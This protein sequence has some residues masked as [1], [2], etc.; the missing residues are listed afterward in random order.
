MQ[1]R[2][3]SDLLILGLVAVVCVVALVLLFVTPR[4]TGQFVFAGNMAQ[5]DPYEGC[6]QLSCKTGGALVLGVE[7][8]AMWAGPP[9]LVRC[10]CPE[11]VT[12]WANGK[13][14]GYR[15]ADVRPIRLVRAY[16]GF[17]YKE[18]ED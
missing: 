7:N 16:E 13:P 17:E 4:N 2:G 14:Q 18:A 9:Q 11:H 1:K 6:A 10:I 8:T 15:A 5:L 3:N 12:S